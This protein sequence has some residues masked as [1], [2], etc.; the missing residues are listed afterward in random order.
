M[1]DAMNRSGCREGEQLESSQYQPNQTRDV[2]R[3]CGRRD[4]IRESIIAGLKR[5]KSEPVAR[6][7]EVPGKDSFAAEISRIDKAIA[8]MGSTIVAEGA[9]EQALALSIVKSQGS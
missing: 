6:L 2:L 9:D 3:L 4:S 5:Q 7:L 8:R 1:S